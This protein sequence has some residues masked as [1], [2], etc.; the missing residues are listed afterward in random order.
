MK[1]LKETILESMYQR[2]DVEK[3]MNDVLKSYSKSM[4]SSMANEIQDDIDEQ[5]KYICD[6]DESYIWQFIC[7]CAKMLKTSADDLW[8]DCGGSYMFAD[9]IANAM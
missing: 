2:K 1:T 3:T 6:N 5:D 8:D 4:I 9:A 7:D